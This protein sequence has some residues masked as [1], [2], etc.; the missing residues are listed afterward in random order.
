[1]S[2]LSLP[3]ECGY[4]KHQQQREDYVHTECN[5]QSAIIVVLYFAVESKLR[6]VNDE[7]QQQIMLMKKIHRNTQ[8]SKQ[9][10]NLLLKSWWWW[11]KFAAQIRFSFILKIFEHHSAPLTT[12]DSNVWCQCCWWNYFLKKCKSSILPSR[13]FV[14]LTCSSF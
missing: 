12:N 6:K 1:M 9:Q 7:I 13:V 14:S 4:E 10:Q 8:H 5:V 2:L 11:W 3:A